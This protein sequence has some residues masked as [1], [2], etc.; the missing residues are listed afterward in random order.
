M[1]MMR[2]VSGAKMP[3][4]AMADGSTVDLLHDTSALRRNGRPAPVLSVMLDWPFAV[5]GT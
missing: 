5:T 4:V 1:W 2:F 3:K